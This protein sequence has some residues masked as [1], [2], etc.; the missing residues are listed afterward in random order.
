MSSSPFGKDFLWGAATSAFQVE[1]A[2]LEDGK[3]LSLA[4][5]RSM[6]IDPQNE[7]SK[8]QAIAGKMTDSSVASDQYHHWR[9]DIALMKELGLRS[10]R[11]SI[12]WPRVLPHGDDAELNPK[13]IKYYDDLVNALREAG[14]EPVVTLYHFDFPAA[15]EEKYGGWKSR[16][17]VE[18]FTRY[19]SL[20]FEHF[21]GRVKWWLVN[22]EQNEMIRRD[23][24]LGINESDPLTRERL[25]HLC[26]HHMFLACAKAIA[27][28]HKIDRTAQIGPVMAFAPRY[29]LDG[30]PEN[31]LAARMA[32]DLFYYYMIDVH[33]QGEYP[34]YYLRW[35]R[36]NGW[37]FDLTEEDKNILK[38]GKPDF[39]AFNY[40]RSACA[41]ACN[42]T[43]PTLFEKYRMDARRRIIP[44]VFQSMDNP[45]IEPDQLNGWRLD[46][47]G[48][49]IAAR[50]IYARCH[51]PLMIC[52]NGFGAPDEMQDDHEIHDSYRIDYLREHIKQLREIMLD[53]IPMLG[54]HVWTLVDVLSTSEG[55][56]KRY[57]LIYVDRTDEDVK[58]CKRY[59]KD[60][61]YW[62]KKV[63]ATNGEDLD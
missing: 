12:S 4:D 60:S 3:G 47:K 2:V 61:F 18:D 19:A 50:E 5:L 31:V 44:G 53:G 34:G 29:P 15:L 57:G 40:Y 8:S 23:A 27:I 42:D 63:I 7:P 51:L 30:R 9:E 37:M 28:C 41:A 35:L 22:N 59:K 58:E 43:D 45:Y 55:F 32:T 48:L 20:M 49:H 56:R 10:Y 13:G 33:V 6:H 16:Q 36:D 62:Y 24:L 38:D 46:P 39:Y 17:A 54:Y 25:K 11:F 1:G 14:V 26:N 21:K 52:E